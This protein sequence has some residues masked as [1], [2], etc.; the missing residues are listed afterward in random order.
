VI[1]EQKGSLLGDIRPTQ[2]E[3]RKLSKRINIIVSAVFILINGNLCAI[4]LFT[5]NLPILLR[6]SLTVPALGLL[7][8]YE[9]TTW[10]RRQLNSLITIIIGALCTIVLWIIFAS[11]FWGELGCLLGSIFLYFAASEL[12]LFCLEDSSFEWH[13]DEISFCS[14]VLIC[15]IAGILSYFI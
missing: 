10:C 13:K 7:T 5:S 12:L 15:I 4:S 8:F 1:I 9:I 3:A 2:A 11:A 6:L 14:F